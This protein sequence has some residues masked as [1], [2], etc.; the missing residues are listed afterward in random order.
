[1]TIPSTGAIGHSEIMAEFG[2][3][4][5]MDL[6]ADGGPLIGKAA[7]T[8]I[9]E[10]EFRGRSS[11]LL[12]LKEGKAKSGY[13]RCTSG[14][15]YS[16]YFGNASGCGATVT[17]STNSNFT[18]EYHLFYHECTTNQEILGLVGKKVRCTY[19][20][21]ASNTTGSYASGGIHLAFWGKHTKNIF[22]TGDDG[23]T[24]N[25]SLCGS[26]TPPNN[27]I[28]LARWGKQDMYSSPGYWD[29]NEFKTFSTLYDVNVT[30]AWFEFEIPDGGNLSQLK[31][32]IGV[33]VITRGYYPNRQFSGSISK[34]S[35]VLTEV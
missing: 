3:S 9:D 24:P 4:G 34:F 2:L 31:T 5:K 7:N 11:S 14:R 26:T 20:L 35:L 29:N 10:S 27:N 30:D 32:K 12:E 21:I 19:T 6:S 25:S 1:M 28:Q 8:R 33:S 16:R 18:A 17:P 15:G 13:G 23:S 22:Y